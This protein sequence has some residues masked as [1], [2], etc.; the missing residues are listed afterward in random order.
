VW[1]CQ[2]LA[3]CAQ[4]RA[5]SSHETQAALQRRRLFTI[6]GVLVK[7]PAG[8]LG[9]AQDPEIADHAMGRPLRSM[10]LSAPT[11]AA[12]GRGGLLVAPRLSL[13][14]AWVRC[15]LRWPAADV[16]LGRKSSSSK[17]PGWLRCWMT[18]GRGQPLGGASSDQGKAEERTA[19]RA[20]FSGGASELAC[21]EWPRAEPL[22]SADEMASLVEST[23]SV[24]GVL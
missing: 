19:A 24:C 10:N 23:G 15:L 21:R 11:L 17:R 20:F 22:Q 4:A 9:L 5:A 14:P 2:V 1:C 6:G 18:A 7:A 16:V 8:C 3:H 12:A 13:Q